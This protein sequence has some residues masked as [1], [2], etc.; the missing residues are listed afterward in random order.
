MSVGAIF[1]GI[2]FAL[3]VGAY[4]ARP[5][6][7]A[8]VDLERAIEAW[9]AEVRAE[10]QGN[11]GVEEQRQHPVGATA[12]AGSEEAEEKV[13][14]CS[15]CGRRVGPDDRFCAGCGA[16]LREGLK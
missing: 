14:Y 15:Q 4:L 1:V 2:A 6:R 7:T 3:V 8:T 12:T 10:G 9:V 13:N 11:R 5:F 16:P